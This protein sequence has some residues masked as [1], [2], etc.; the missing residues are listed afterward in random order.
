[1]QIKKDIPIPQSRIRGSKYDFLKK[2]EI[3]DC[4]CFEK[5]RDFERHRDALRYFK[6]PHITRK[7]QTNKILEY[8]IW[9]TEEE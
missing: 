4:V 2:L 1:M 8:R 6:I 9:I 7:H 3:G 5:W